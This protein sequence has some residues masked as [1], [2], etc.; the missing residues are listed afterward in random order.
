[1][2]FPKLPL[3]AASLLVALALSPAPARAM[4][5]GPPTSTDEARHLALGQPAPEAS[6]RFAVRGPYT[7]TDEARA[8]AVIRAAPASASRP[9]A[10]GRPTTTDQARGIDE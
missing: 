8:S 6:L 9:I 3:A 7:T 1:M 5:L 10:A 2:A 4:H